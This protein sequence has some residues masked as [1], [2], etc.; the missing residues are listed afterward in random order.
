MKLIDKL[1]E[2]YL[3]SHYRIPYEREDTGD[4]FQAG[5]CAA[6]EMTAE[7]LAQ[8]MLRSGRGG[9]LKMPGYVAGGRQTDEMSLSD[10]IRQLGEEEV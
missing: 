3:D 5:F 7:T 1:T 8:F 6:R 2:Q 9:Y 10:L 4:A